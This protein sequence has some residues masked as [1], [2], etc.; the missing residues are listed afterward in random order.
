MKL[1]WKGHILEGDVEP[2]ASKALFKCA[3]PG[4]VYDGEFK[5]DQITGCGKM[6]WPEGHVYTGLWV[7]GDRDGLGE[8]KLSDGDVY[9]GM[10]SKDQ[11]NGLGEFLF[12]DGQV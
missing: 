3:A 10:W 9:C 5:G 6:V 12:A 1:N 4:Y 8:I 11:R 7:N 2:G